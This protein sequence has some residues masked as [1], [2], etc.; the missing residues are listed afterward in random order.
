MRHNDITSAVNLAVATD[1][2]RTGTRI[3]MPLYAG[4]PLRLH[5]SVLVRQMARPQVSPRPAASRCAVVEPSCTRWR[6]ADHLP[7]KRCG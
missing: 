7:G 4:F 6:S 5:A 3:A 2:Q 1:S